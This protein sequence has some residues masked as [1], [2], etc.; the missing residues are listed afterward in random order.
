MKLLTRQQKQQQQ[1][2]QHKVRGRA[3][4]KGAWLDWDGMERLPGLLIPTITIC[5][6]SNREQVNYETHTH[7]QSRPPSRQRRSERE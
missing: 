7:T 3:T 1:Q 2:Q 4:Q 6:Q 5:W